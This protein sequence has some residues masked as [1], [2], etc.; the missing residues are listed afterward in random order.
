[1]PRRE[2]SIFAAAK[3]REPASSIERTRDGA[4]SD[5]DQ[6]LAATCIISWIVSTAIWLAYF[7]GG[8]AA[9]AVAHG[10]EKAPAPSIFV[11][12]IAG[13]MPRFC[14]SRIDD[15]EAVFVVLAYEADVGASEVVGRQARRHL[16]DDASSAAIGCLLVAFVARLGLRALRLDAV[17][18][19]GDRSAADRSGRTRPCRRPSPSGSSRPPRPREAKSLDRL[20]ALEGLLG[21]RDL[22][23]SGFDAPS[24]RGRS[25]G[26]VS[27]AWTRAADRTSSALPS[28]GPPGIGTSLRDFSTSASAAT[29]ASVSDDALGRPDW[30]EPELRGLAFRHGLPAFTLKLMPPPVPPLDPGRDRTGRDVVRP[31]TGH[32]A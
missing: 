4:R 8:R 25:N 24:T 32:P 10:E 9:H 15:E 31:E 27:R 11:C 20:V 3:I 2:R 13:P 21:R 7:A 26:A 19:S 16:F 29:T 5:R 22:H 17:S 12:R 18:T 30:P 14:F 1:M 6:R 23:S 28:A